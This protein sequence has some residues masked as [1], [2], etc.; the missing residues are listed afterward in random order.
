MSRHKDTPVHRLRHRQ[1]S[2]HILYHLHVMRQHLDYMNFYLYF[3]RSFKGQ[4]ACRTLFGFIFYCW[5]CRISSRRWLIGVVSLLIL[6]LNSAM[7]SFCIFGTPAQ[8]LLL[9]NAQRDSHREL[10]LH[11]VDVAVTK[12]SF[13]AFLR[14][15]QVIFFLK[16]SDLALIANRSPGAFGNDCIMYKSALSPLY[17]LVVNLM[18]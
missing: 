13:E 15:C 16:S 10:N 12:I 7:L 17:E 1:C 6:H 2:D 5:R 4:Y 8:T 14:Q 11:N 9:W 18:K 3:Y